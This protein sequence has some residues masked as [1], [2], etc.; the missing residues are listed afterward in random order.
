M[1]IFSVVHSTKTKNKNNNKNK[2]QNQTN[3]NSQPHSRDIPWYLSQGL[4][5]W[6]ADYKRR[7]KR[8]RGIQVI[9]LRITFCYFTYDATEPREANLARFPHLVSEVSIQ[10]HMISSKDSSFIQGGKRQMKI[11]RSFLSARSTDLQQWLRCRGKG[12]HNHADG[13]CK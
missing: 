3:K 2:K 9:K 4:H 11:L 12:T 6:E 5:W 10:I 7:C 13:N 8:I 1:L